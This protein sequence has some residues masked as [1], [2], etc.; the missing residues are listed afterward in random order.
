MKKIS[1][2]IQNELQQKQLYF[3]DAAQEIANS[4]L[5]LLKTISVVTAVL[6]VC[7]MLIT[8]LVIPGWLPSLQHLL[9][10][11]A[12]FL[13]ICLIFFCEKKSWNKPEQ[14]TGICLLFE[15]VLFLFLIAIDVLQAPD[16][17]ASFMP[18]LCVSMPTLLIL[19]FHLH[20][21]VIIFF[22][23]IYI[24]ATMQYK[25]LFIAQYDIFNSIV[26]IAFSF[27]L[28]LITMHLRIQD[29]KTRTRYQQLS[30]QDALSGLLNKT[31]CQE[32]ANR[33]L[34]QTAPATTCTL[35]ILDLD[36]FKRIND[37]LGHYTGDAILQH[38]GTTLAGT[39]RS[40]DIVGRFG[41][42]EF[43]I[44]VKDTADYATLKQKCS[45]IHQ[46]LQNALEID[47][48]IP[49]TCSIGGVLVN[50]QNADFDSLFKQA[51]Q[52]LYQAKAAG[53]NNSILHN[54]QPNKP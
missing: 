12:A 7:L 5:R 25:T 27:S 4:N 28:A 8:P 49:T 20:Y 1:R 32:A 15:A 3:Q 46:K 16:I 39:F 44:L 26:G 36:N 21:A 33:Y 35:L 38:I 47:C 6:L 53:K 40:T 54:Y 34:E 31:A 23:A 51:D 24:A 37:E 13:L 14:V 48:S 18:M 30:L 22:E 43:L 2:F 50:G 45:L 29:H 52:A 11:P 17:P 10:L 9:F 42:D 41:G 19:P